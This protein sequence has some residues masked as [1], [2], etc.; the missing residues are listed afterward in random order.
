MTI[1]FA[2]NI[3]SFAQVMTTLS[4]YYDGLLEA[5]VCAAVRT[6]LKMG[7]NAQKA[8]YDAWFQLSRP[9]MEPVAESK[10]DMVEKIDI[11]NAELMKLLFKHYR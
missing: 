5:E 1:I 7:Q 4:Y 9:G 8:S 6:L 2:E 11:S 3:T 10:L